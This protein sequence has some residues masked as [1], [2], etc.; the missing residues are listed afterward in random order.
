MKPPL[1]S[2][3]KTPQPSGGKTRHVALFRIVP[4]YVYT[5]HCGMKTIPQRAVA[6]MRLSSLPCMPVCP[7]AATREPLR[8]LS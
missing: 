5:L 4:V 2:S 1:E 8:E 3:V 7:R 6:S